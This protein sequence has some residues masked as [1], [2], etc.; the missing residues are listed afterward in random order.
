M[1]QLLSIFL[2][3]S[4]AWGCSGILFFILILVYCLNRWGSQT[5]IVLKTVGCLVLFV[6]MPIGA[7]F[8]GVNVNGYLSAEGGIFGQIKK[9]LGLNKV[10]VSTDTFEISELNLRL[11]E[12]GEYSAKINVDIE[13]SETTIKINRDKN[14]ILLVNGEL[15]SK[16]FMYSTGES[17]SFS[18]DYSYTF[19]DFKKD[20]IL[21]D[22]LHI[23]FMINKNDITCRLTSN[24][25]AV[26]QELWK[27]YNKKNGMK[28]RF[29]QSDYRNPSNISEGV[30]DTS[31]YSILTF[32]DENNFN[33]SRVVLTGTP[34]KENPPLYST[35]GYTFE[36]WSIDG[37][38]VFDF[39][40]EINEDLT[41]NPILFQSKLVLLDENYNV[42]YRHRMLGD[43]LSENGLIYNGEL[44]V[45]VEI[46]NLVLNIV[47]N[48]ENFTITDE[49]GNV[50]AEKRLYPSSYDM[51]KHNVKLSRV[52]NIDCSFA[53]YIAFEKIY[54]A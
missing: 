8:C 10:N 27:V 15:T 17:V 6:A 54:V 14:Y 5:K 50:Y 32:K 29:I 41:F 3:E 11:D 25:G 1:A 44:V 33:I 48:E 52:T 35:D 7:V 40:Q 21:K 28:I 2:P 36:G 46:D 45:N 39:T 49:Q 34:L 26:A 24:G 23:Y 4:L 31:Q 16:N 53:K 43:Y 37:K 20:E 12:N 30:G 38:N 13:D 9:S 47:F 51:D 18:A 42:I 19:K 22:T